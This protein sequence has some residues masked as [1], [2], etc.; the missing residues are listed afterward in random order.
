MLHPQYK[1]VTG[2]V[3][4]IFGHRFVVKTGDGDL[5]A[6]L[7]P[8]G[9]DQIALRLNDDVLSKARSSRRN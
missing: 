2:K 9:L 4:H 5:L 7:T 3:T 6:D 8:K 1:T